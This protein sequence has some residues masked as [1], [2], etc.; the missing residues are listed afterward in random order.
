MLVIDTLSPEAHAARF[1]RICEDAMRERRENGKD[2]IGTLAE[3]WQ[4]Q[5]IKRYLYED[6]NDHEVKLSGTRFVSDVRVGNDIYEVQTGSFRPMQKKIACY[7]ERPELTVTVVHPIPKDCWI[8]RIDPDTEKISPRKKS[9]RHGRAE[10]LLPELYWLLPHLGDPRLRFR[11]LL[12]EVHDFRLLG[13][14]TKKR[15]RQSVKFERIPLTLYEDTELLTADDFRRFL[16]NTLPD[17]FTVRNF[18]ACTGIRGKD[19]YSAV[20]ALS[21]LGLL[22]PAESIRGAMA[23]EQ[24]R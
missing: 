15:A 3:K 16:P 6:P 21:A 12:L 22:S 11:I 18:S 13:Q 5:I 8:S 17:V 4:H 14:R 24:S 20:R 1:S 19:A 7:L 10:D 2:G 9:P 23:F